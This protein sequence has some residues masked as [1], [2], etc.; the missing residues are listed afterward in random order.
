MGEIYQQAESVQAWLSS[1]MD[2]GNDADSL[3]KNLQESNWGEEI[4]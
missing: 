4:V 2:G 1:E 3:I